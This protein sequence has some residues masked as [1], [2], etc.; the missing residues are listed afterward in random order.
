MNQIPKTPFLARRWTRMML[1]FGISISLGMAP[2]LGYVQI[3]GFVSLLALFPIYP[4]D[5]TKQLVAVTSLLMGLIALLVQYFQHER[6]SRAKR[7]RWFLKIS[8]ALVTCLLLIFAIYLFNVEQVGSFNIL[9]GWSEP[10]CIQCSGIT[11]SECIERITATTAD[12]DRCFGSSRVRG[13]AFVLAFLYMATL[14]LLGTLVGL[15]VLR[16]RK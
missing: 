6:A 5:F 4:F 3:P 15:L 9:I 7:N 11:R 10:Q 13:A 12:V 16:E 1:A 2:L 14:S 8:T